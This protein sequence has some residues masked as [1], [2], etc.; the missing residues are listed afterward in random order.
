M[1]VYI[2]TSAFMALVSVG[3]PQ[4]ENSVAAWTELVSNRE[5]LVTSSYVIHETISL[6]HSRHGSESVGH[7][8]QELLRPV[9]VEWVGQ[10]LYESALAAVLVVAGKSGPSLTDCVGFDLIRRH[11]IAG[12]FAYDRHFA[13]QGFNLIGQG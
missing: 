13:G 8:V 12:V 3:D 4:H 5:D 1:S 9:R 2:D 10:A 6:L 11:R 7:F